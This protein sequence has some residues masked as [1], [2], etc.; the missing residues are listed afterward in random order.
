[1]EVKID[2]TV[3]KR[4]VLLETTAVVAMPALVDNPV[5]ALVAAAVAP[6]IPIFAPIQFSPAL[7]P[8]LIPAPNA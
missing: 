4:K 1:M 5:I 2:F 6:P 7:I 8:Y 3:P